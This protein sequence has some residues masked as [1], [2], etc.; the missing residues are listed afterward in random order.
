MN[1]EQNDAKFRELFQELKRQ[2]VRHAPRFDDVLRAKKSRPA[3]SPWLL[4]AAAILIIA[5]LGV[6]ALLLRGSSASHPAV[7]LVAPVAKAPVT[8]TLGDWQAPTDA[9]LELPGAGWSATNP[10]FDTEVSEITA[11]RLLEAPGLDGTQT[12]KEDTV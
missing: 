10:S 8:F 2:D 12:T 6:A 1:T 11:S 7:A 9:L 5:T 3:V 4:R